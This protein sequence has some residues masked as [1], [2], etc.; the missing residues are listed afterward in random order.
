MFYPKIPIFLLAV[1]MSTS[2]L[3]VANNH[4][5]EE[6]FDEAFLFFELNDTDG[7]LGIHG[8]FDGDAWKVLE[9]KDPNERRMLKV[10]AS[11]RLKRQGMTEL[12]FESAEPCF[13]PED[14]DDPLDPDDFFDR[15]PQGKYEIEGITL[16]GKELESE[17]ILSHIM[18]AAPSDVM[19][20][21]E[22]AAEDCDA[23]ELP[24]VSLPVILSWNAAEISHEELGRAG[25]VQIR[26]YEVVVEI[27]E[28]DYNSTSIIPR[29]PVDGRV[30]WTIPSD[31]FTLTAGENVDEYKF[32]IL[33]R[34]NVYDE[35]DKL[36]K[37]KIPGL[38]GRG[39][40][41]GNKSAVESCF[42][43]ID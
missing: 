11:G 1:A 25:P 10:R 23:D 9:I 39:P 32:E 36:V 26:Y 20:N 31:F 6:P 15:F 16:D 38:R 27:D 12:F 21:D 34:T 8:K 3:V 43:I 22:A 42:T 24:A 19:V 33:I 30:S 17:V 2:T 35:H 5:E 14:C 28:S 7:D 13:D 37:V 29:V 4:D 18:P 41:P 40:L